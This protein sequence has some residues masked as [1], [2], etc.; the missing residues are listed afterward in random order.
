MPMFVETYLQLKDICSMS[1]IGGLERDITSFPQSLPFSPLYLLSCGR[2]R[3]F[4]SEYYKFADESIKLE[5]D[6]HEA[7]KEVDAD[8][9]HTNNSQ[10]LDRYFAENLA[11]P[12]LSRL[13]DSTNLA[14][15]AQM[16]I[17]IEYLEEACHGL[18]GL[19]LASR[20]AQR[21]TK[22][23]LGA[24]TDFRKTRQKAEERVFEVLNSKIDDFLDLADYDWLHSRFFADSDVGYRRQRTQNLARTSKMWRDSSTSQSELRCEI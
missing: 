19:L 3:N 9:K 13:L 14:Q 7:L 1:L 24:T 16:L 2:I 8:E 22:V 18:E 10:S 21:P 15:V 17:N 23:D 4:V 12:L 5:Q 20:S 11:Q 6:I